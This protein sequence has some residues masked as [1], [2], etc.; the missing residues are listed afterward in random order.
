[1]HSL[2]TKSSFAVVM[3]AVI[4]SASVVVAAAGTSLAPRRPAST[5]AF[6]SAPSPCHLHRALASWAST[7]VRPLALTHVSR[8]NWPGPRAPRT[9]RPPS[10]PTPRIPVP[11]TLRTGQRASSPRAC[12]AART[13]WPARTT[14]AGTRRDSPSPTPSTRRRRTAGRHQR[15]RPLRRSGGSTWKQ[16]TSGR[17]SNTDDVPRRA[18]TT[19]RP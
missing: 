14:T 10:T 4:L 12:A 17:P 6:R 18:R 8:E 13:R 15:P 16:G 9:Q 7:R 5:S 2:L 11:R 19:R 3:T 1:M